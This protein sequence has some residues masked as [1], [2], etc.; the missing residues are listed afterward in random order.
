L[1][2]AVCF[3][4]S[5]LKRVS[6]PEI[7][8]GAD[9]DPREVE[10]SLADLRTV[11]RLFG[12]IR[13]SEVLFRRVLSQAGLREFSVLDVGSGT[14]DVPLAIHARLRAEGIDAAVTLF[15]QHQNHLP[16]LKG[17]DPL[18][19]VMTGDALHL[20]FVENWF[21]VVSCSL[22][23]HHLEPDQVRQ[24]ATQALRVARHA[25]IINDL[26]RSQLHYSMLPLWRPFFRSRVSYLDG[27]TSVRRAYTPQEIAE[28]LS[29]I[30]RVEITRHFF[31][32]MGII[33]WK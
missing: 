7:L 28:M 19:H 4:P 33:L 12:G 13:T 3:H 1:R 24:F 2:F 23:L 31:Y 27:R 32:R 9:L 22:F 30:G 6:Q 17:D 29:G 10:Q 25:V 21:D 20:P 15:D 11:N 8:D 16:H 18:L 5:T 26:V 14:G